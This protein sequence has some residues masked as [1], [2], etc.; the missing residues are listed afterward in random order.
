MQESPRQ[1]DFAFRRVGF[2]PGNGFCAS[3]LPIK[4]ASL[5]DRGKY[6]VKYMHGL[7]LKKKET[8]MIQRLF[9]YDS[10]AINAMGNLPIQKLP[11]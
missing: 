8:C 2:F 3:E 5:R 4:K 10:L 1:S 7:N 11:V 9:S 6:H